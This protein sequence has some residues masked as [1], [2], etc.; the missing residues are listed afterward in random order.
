MQGLRLTRPLAEAS[1]RVDAI[2]LSV[3]LFVLYTMVRWLTSPT[4]S[5]SRIEAMEV[6]AYA[7][8]FWICRYGMANRK[9]S[10]SRFYFCSWILGVGETA[11]GYYLSHWPNPHDPA[12]Q[13]FPFGPTERFH[14]G[15]FPRWVG[16]YASSNH[17]AFRLLVMA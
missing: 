15:Y 9:R 12:T 8:I 17:Y 14:L 5:F 10:R 4:E 2:D 3:A 16:T 1:W 11:F 7:G 6:A 13:W